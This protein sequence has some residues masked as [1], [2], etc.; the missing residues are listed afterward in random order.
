MM[1]TNKDYL[2]TEV[3]NADSIESFEDPAKD[4]AFKEKLLKK[5]R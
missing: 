2:K 5:L 3:D 4:D 1:P